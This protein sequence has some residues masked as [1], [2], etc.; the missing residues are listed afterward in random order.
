[1]SLTKV[2]SQDFCCIVQQEVREQ[3]RVAFFGSMLSHCLRHQIDAR[4]K[5]Y[6]LF[7]INIINAV[8]LLVTADRR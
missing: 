8:Q 3:S 7:E 5:P 2:R 1:M 6:G 4:T